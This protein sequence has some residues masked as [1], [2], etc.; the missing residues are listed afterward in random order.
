MFGD[1]TLGAGWSGRF[2]SGEVGCVPGCRCPYYGMRGITIGS[3]DS[4]ITRR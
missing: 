4:L 3:N 1:V 2:P